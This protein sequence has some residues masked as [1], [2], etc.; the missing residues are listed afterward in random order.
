MPGGDIVMANFG[1]LDDLSNQL[2]G[3][4]QAIQ[5]DMDAWAQAVGLADAAWLDEAGAAFSA[6]SAAW[7]QVSLAQQDMLNALGLGVV[8]ANQEYFGTL[9]AAVSRVGSTGPGG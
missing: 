4:L 9:R 5:A 6:V 7:D 1:M 2:R 3:T 8:N